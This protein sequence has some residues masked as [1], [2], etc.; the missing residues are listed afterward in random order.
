MKRLAAQWALPLALIACWELAARVGWLS[1]RILPEPWAVAT[2][3][4]TLTISGELLLH[5]RTSLW[6][7]RTYPR[8]GYV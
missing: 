7:N 5:L 4:W 3:F 6:R 1:S 2:A 8:G